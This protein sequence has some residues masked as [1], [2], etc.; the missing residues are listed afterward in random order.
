MLK[1]RYTSMITW[2]STKSTWSKLK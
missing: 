2:S 1:K